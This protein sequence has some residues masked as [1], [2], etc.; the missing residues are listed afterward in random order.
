M[1]L[2][3][4]LLLLSLA[5]PVAAQDYLTLEQLNRRDQKAYDTALGYARRGQMDDALAEVNQVLEREPLAIDALL[6][7]AGIQHDQGQLAASE[8][9]YEQVL[10][11][12]PDHSDLAYYQLALTELRMEKYSESAEHFTTFL[13][14]PD[15]SERRRERA[16]SYL[17]DAQLGAELKENPVD[18]EPVS[19]GD[20]INTPGQEVLPSFTADGQTL[21]YTTK[22]N[23]Q[24]DFYFSTRGPDGRWRKGQPL[25]ALNTPNDEGAQN[26]SADGRLLL[27]TSCYRRD[28]YGRCD[29]Y[30]AE[31]H[32]GRWTEARN[33][34]ERINTPGWESQPSL[35]ANGQ[36]FYFTSDRR[37]GKGGNDIWISYRQPN[38]EW[39]EPVNAGDV[40]NT[41]G[42]EESPFL[43]PD[44][45]TLYFMSD[46]HP[47]LGSYDLFVAR[48][49]SNGQWQQ[50]RN[51][52]YPINTPAAEGALFVS[53]DGTTAYYASNHERPQDSGRTDFDIYQFPLYQAARPQPVTFV[54]G[55]V[56]HAASHRPLAGVVV[57]V[58]ANQ[59]GQ[60]P[61]SV[62]TDAD[63]SFLLV[64]PAGQDYAFTAM[65][66]GFLFYSDRF[67]LADG[68]SRQDPF[69]LEIALQPV[70][71]AAEPA[72]G[73]PVVLRNVLFATDSA[74]LLSAS[75]AE[76]DRLV[77]LLT[78]YPA[79]RIQINGHTDNVGQPADNQQLSEDRARAVYDYLVEAGIAAERLSYQGVGEDKPLT[80][81]DTA[82]GRRQNRRT[83][84]V[85][86]GRSF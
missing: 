33:M 66:D 52:G 45:Q 35:S 36:M 79:L 32:N 8:A 25:D 62:T 64:L 67:F 40:I 82:E 13:A 59:P 24:E 9:D 26:I 80:S 61:N 72:E 5:V 55:Q 77:Q 65:A 48:L 71:D 74:E 22:Y 16:T 81:N 17:A 11:L 31:K 27:F 30:Y 68:F 1:R 47:G 50:P 2:L 57:Q 51:L 75:T 19:L 58:T 43:H 12:A 29:L 44:G 18:F 21:V 42:N 76:L 28:G 56:I 49:D 39:G 41:P 38:G 85:V 86:I 15:I 63:G 3:F 4:F 20:S 53:L 83:E 84:F 37:G 7:R 54:Q 60:A 10:T 34:G 73:E 70:P 78:D 69:E 6:L 23:S 14:R 46:G